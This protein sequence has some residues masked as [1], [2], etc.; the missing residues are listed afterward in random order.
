MSCE[1]TQDLRPVRDELERII[2]IFKVPRHFIRTGFYDVEYD[3][4]PPSTETDL[5]CASCENPPPFNSNLAKLQIATRP[6]LNSL[7]E[8]FTIQR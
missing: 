6:F 1:Q 2:A 8:N 7:R 4:L 3:A 5:H